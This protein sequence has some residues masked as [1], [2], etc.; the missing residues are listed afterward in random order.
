MRPRPSPSRPLAR[1]VKL[2]SAFLSWCDRL[3]L[4]HLQDGAQSDISFVEPKALSG[5]AHDGASVRQASSCADWSWPS[6]RPMPLAASVGRAHSPAPPRRP[7][8]QSDSVPA[9]RASGTGSCGRRPDGTEP[10]AGRGPQSRPP[11]LKPVAHCAT[12][13]GARAA[14]R[15]AT[16]A[17]R[18]RGTVRV[19]ELGACQCRPG[20]Q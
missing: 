1:L 3:Q 5:G 17:T 13:T 18:G 15:R 10:Q 9:R 20:P 6:D 16:G 19:T 8:S 4:P 11:R 2:V 14:R 12:R 7:V